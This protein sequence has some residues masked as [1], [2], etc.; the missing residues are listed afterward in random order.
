MQEIKIIKGNKILILIILLG[1]CGGM[2][3]K[4]EAGTPPQIV[5]LRSSKLGVYRTALK[6][7]KKH[8]KQKKSNAVVTDFCL[9]NTTTNKPLT[10]SIIKKKPDLILCL[11]PA[12]ARLANIH[13]KHLPFIFCMIFDPSEEKLTRAGLLV[14]VHPSEQI[15]FIRSTFPKLKKVCVFYEEDKNIEFISAL[16]KQQKKG[17]KNLVLVKSDSF[18]S[19]DQAMDKLK[20]KIDC[21]LMIPNLTLYPP[22]RASKIILKS[23]QLRIPLIAPSLPY[24]RAGAVGGIFPDYKENGHNAAKLALEVLSGTKTRNIPLKWPKPRVT[25]INWLVAERMDIV[26]DPKKLEK[27]SVVI[28]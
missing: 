5:A 26:V 24:V 14:N 3:R 25:A 22:N 8:L 1:I 6:G 18:Q 2:T 12:A 20:Q 16:I 13:L 9:D 4:I 11:G 28:E 7:F 17:D 19:I 10:Q 23:I 21:V 27:A 15:K